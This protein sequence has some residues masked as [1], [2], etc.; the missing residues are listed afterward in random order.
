VLLL[1]LFLPP[2][3]QGT[4]PSLVRLLP[5]SSFFAPVLALLLLAKLGPSHI[6]SVILLAAEGTWTG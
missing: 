4:K 1:C 3:K 6:W 2:T 5:F